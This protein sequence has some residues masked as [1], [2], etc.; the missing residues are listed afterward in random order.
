MAMPTVST[1]R[2]VINYLT[3]SDNGLTASEAKNRYG[4]KRLATV[5]HHIK[6][7]LESNGNWEIVTETTA[8]GNVRYFAND[9]HPN[10]TY[11]FDRMGK[12]VMVTA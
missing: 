8:R 9:V 7:Q 1:R 3:T 10:R 11:G 4:I 12:R 2:K 5:M 6:N